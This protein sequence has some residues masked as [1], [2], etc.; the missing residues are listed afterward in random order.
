M[1][2]I[3]V[4]IALGG[5]AFAAIGKNTVDSKQIVTDAVGAKE[6]KKSAVAS[7]E[8]RDGSVRPD[9]LGFNRVLGSVNDG[10]SNT[11]LIGEG[12]IGTGDI[13]NGQVLL[14]D[15]GADAVGTVQLGDGS[16][17]PVDLAFNRVLGSVNDGT[18][19]TLLIGEGSIGTGDIG[20][21]QVLLPDIGAD[22]VGT[23][24]LGDGSV[25]SVDIDPALGLTCPAGTN[26]FQGACIETSNRGPATF[27]AALAACVADG[28]WLPDAGQLRGF[29]MRA[30][31]S[32]AASSE[33]AESKYYDRDWDGGV[34]ARAFRA[35]TVGEGAAGDADTDAT[36][37][38]M[39]RCVAPAAGA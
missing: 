29:G 19:N 12:S 21:G 7:I 2:T 27:D 6:I 15:I 34:N 33:W 3:A 25:R 23:V 17:R 36:A 26:I 4:F 16:I 14:P 35:P 8:L 10:T 24:Q 31:V 18:S 22:A 37:S 30:S 20:N 32:L 1:A 38:R 5:G 9:D 11:L 13:G 28:R 39:Y